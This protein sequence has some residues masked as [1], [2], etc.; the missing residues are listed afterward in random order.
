MTLHNSTVFKLL[1]AAMAGVVLMLAAKTTAF[2]VFIFVAGH[3]Q[4]IGQQGPIIRGQIEE[5]QALIS[6]YSFYYDFVIPGKPVIFRQVQKTSMLGNVTFMRKNLWSVRGEVD[7]RKE[8]KRGGFEFVPRS[9]MTFSDFLD[10]FETEDLYWDEMIPMN[11]TILKNI[12]FPLPINCEEITATIQYINLMM[13]SGGVSYLLHDDDADNMFYLLSGE[14]TWL[15]ANSSFKSQAYVGAVPHRPGF[16][17]VVPDAVDLS[18]F[19]K[20]SEVEFHEVKLKAG[21]LLYVPRNWPHYVRS[22]ASPNI[23]INVWFG[24]KHYLSFV[25]DDLRCTRQRKSPKHLL[26]T[27]EFV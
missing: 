7:H 20:M 14:K 17:P 1:P 12:P 21:D 13:S 3:L 8:W 19:P 5:F 22:Y 18:R 9:V 26:R 16:S 15:I 23:A 2:G 11:H 25:P 27:Q 24:G 6:G 10:R 4:Q